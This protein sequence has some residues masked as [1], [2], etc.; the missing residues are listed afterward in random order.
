MVLP[1]LYDSYPFIAPEKY[2]GKLNGKVAI[3]TGASSGIGVGI[4]KAMAAAGANVACV[5]RREADLNKVVDEIKSNG[6][7][8]VAIVSDIS[9]RGAAKDLIANVESQ[10]GP[11]DILVNNAGI[12]RLGAVQ[13]E[14]EDLDVWWRVYE[15]NVRA[16]VTL[17]RAVLPSMLKRKTGKL[18]TVSSAVATMGLPAMSAYNSSKAAISK[19]HEGIQP[20]LEGSGIVTFALNPGMVE[21]GLG[22]P[23]D[24]FNP[25]SKDH[26]AVVAFMD[27]IRKGGIQ[28]QSL[29]VPSDTVVALAADDRFNVLSGRHVDA[30]QDLE[31]VV[32]EAE[33]E[34]K[35]RL[36]SERLYLVNIGSL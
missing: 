6:H 11:I 9:K 7:K 22:A 26:P 13:D 35:G 28:R 1:T 16:P 8:A 24:A 3:V 21:S 32:K 12:T 20:E 19:F 10:L 30:V 4:C 2:K 31:P 33:K 23:G 27:G 29:A 25:A 36:G 18:I 5:A 14:D 15:V 17:I 34:G